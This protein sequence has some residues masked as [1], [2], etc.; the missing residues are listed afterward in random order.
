MN[1]IAF[2]KSILKNPLLISLFDYS[3]CQLTPY[4]KEGL[5]ILQ[6]DKKLGFDLFKCNYKTVRQKLVSGILATSACT[7]FVQV[8]FEANLT[9]NKYEGSEGETLRQAAIFL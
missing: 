4:R 1:A 2:F 7:D 8:I 5:M 3:G 6:V 9:E